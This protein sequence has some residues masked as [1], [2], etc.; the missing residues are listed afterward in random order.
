MILFSVWGVYGVF[1][2]LFRAPEVVPM[3]AVSITLAGQP[4]MSAASVELIREDVAR[5]LVNM[6]VLYALMG[7]VLM[8]G[9]TLAG[10]GVKML[11][12]GP[13]QSS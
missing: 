8:A 6:F 3:H 12:R 4:G 10:L 2:G 5:Q 7:F 11:C 1:S 9:S 13:A